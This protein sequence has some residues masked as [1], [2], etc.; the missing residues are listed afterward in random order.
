MFSACSSD[1]PAP[2]RVS[3]KS[4][5]RFEINSQQFTRAN[6]I[7]DDGD[8]QDQDLRIDAYY[9][10]TATAYISNAQLVYA[11]GSWRFDDGSGTE[12]HYYWPIEGSIETT[13][14]ITVGS[15]DFV[16][17]MPYVQPP[18]ISDMSYSASGPSIT[19]DMSSYMTSSAQSGITELMCAFVTNQTKD[20]NSGTV[21]MS[22]KHP[23]ACIRFQL[24]AA[25]GSDVQA[26]TITIS[27]L[28]TRGACS[29][30]GSTSTWSDWSGTANLVVSGDPATG[31]TPYLVIP[32]NYG[33]MTLTV[34]ATWSGFGS[35]TKDVSTD[36]D[37]NWLPGYSYTYT[38]TLKKDGLIVDVNK[39]TEQW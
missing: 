32:N 22:F 36:I 19:C 26:N 14:D 28:Y 25:S 1:E 24:S 7:S 15:L 17:Y 29:F 37:I 6:V 39:Y 31:D 30:D 12:V 33:A 10:G 27:N 18:Y 8:L 5:L 13:N 11:G 23:F 9:N 21:N 2:P 34:N 16:G 38:L 3:E 20:T 35:A 4:E